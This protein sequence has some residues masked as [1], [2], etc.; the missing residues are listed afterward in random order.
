MNIRNKIQY[1]SKSNKIVKD[2][3]WKEIEYKERKL[4]KSLFIKV[5]SILTLNC[6]LMN[7][8][9]LQNYYKL[10]TNEEL[11]IKDKWIEIITNRQSYLVLD[12]IT[13][14]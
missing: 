2:E 14:T 8:D 9:K 5:T 4:N 1:K 7:W 6:N 11:G 13:F 10:Y 3:T 12:L